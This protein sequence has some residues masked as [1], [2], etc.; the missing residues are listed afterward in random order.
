MVCASVRDDNPRALASGLST[1]QTHEPYSS[2]LHQ[3]ASIP[4]KIFDVKLWNFYVCG[5]SR[6]K[7]QVP[8]GDLSPVLNF[9]TKT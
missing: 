9:D 2:L 8:T 6:H 1:V 5:I 7:I 3:Y 4:Y